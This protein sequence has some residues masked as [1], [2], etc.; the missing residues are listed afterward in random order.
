MNRNFWAFLSKHKV[1]GRKTLR[2][3]AFMYY[4]WKLMKDPNN[5]SLVFKVGFI[6]TGETLDM[7]QEG[8]KNY[9][10]NHPLYLE[11]V[12]E[13]YRPTPYKLEELTQYEP[14]TLGHAYYTHMT[15]NG[16]QLEFYP[17]MQITD[18][19]SYVEQRGNETHDIW[20]A[21]TGYDIDLEGE[22]ALQAFSFGM[23]DGEDS[24]ASMLMG[25]GLTHA[26][27]YEPGK[28][29][30]IFV[31]MME[32]YQRGKAA[33]N[34]LPVKWEEMWARPLAEVRTELN[35][36]GKIGTW[37]KDDAEKPLLSLVG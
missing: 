10:T 25:M 7:P 15:R 36:T 17:K 34:F 6:M 23:M 11:M 19:L 24:F 9:L 27:L 14:G 20:H 33:K 28:M 26:A 5:T 2:G 12:A 37:H 21:V 16:L 29:K 3:L 30:S 4:F 31:A 13:R 32:G 1:P 8:V 22:F 35:V 18:E